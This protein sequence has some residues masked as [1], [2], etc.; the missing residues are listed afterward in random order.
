M[1]AAEEKVPPG[2]TDLRDAAEELGQGR[3]TRHLRR[4]YQKG[5]FPRYIN[6]S[7]RIF[8]VKTSLY[9]Q[10]KAERDMEAEERSAQ[11]EMRREFLNGAD[12]AP[13]FMRKP[14]PKKRRPRD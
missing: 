4:L 3:S 12:N 1:N 13:A 9:E 5:R 8:A 14:K 6:V 2:Y 7:D 11:T 10:W